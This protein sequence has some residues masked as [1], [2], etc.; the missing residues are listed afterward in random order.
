ML[1]DLL[2]PSPHVDIVLGVTKVRG[3]AGTKVSSAEDENLGAG[4][5]LWF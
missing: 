2:L 4:G 1:D 5:G 3:E